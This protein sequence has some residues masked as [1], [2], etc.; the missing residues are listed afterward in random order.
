MKRVYALKKTGIRSNGLLPA[1]LNEDTGEMM[2]VKKIDLSWTGLKYDVALYYIFLAVTCLM[3]VFMINIL[4]SRIGR[5]FQ[6]IRDSDIAASVI[7]INLTYYKTLS[8]AISAFYV[9]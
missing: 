3:V 7:G 5:A 1:G 9:L 6:A 8:F 2:N 4:K